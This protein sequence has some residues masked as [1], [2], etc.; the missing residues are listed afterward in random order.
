MSASGAEPNL[1][2]ELRDCITLEGSVARRDVVKRIEAFVF[3]SPM[4]APVDDG[5]EGKDS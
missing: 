2:V 3:S 1:T 4:V 5:R